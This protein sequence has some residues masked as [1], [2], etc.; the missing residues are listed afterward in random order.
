MPH[1]VQAD[2]RV[3]GVVFGCRRAS[4]GRFLMVRRSAQVILPGKVCFPGGGVCVGESQAAACVR[5]AREELGVSL[6]PIGAVWLHAF[7]DR[8]LTLFGWLAALDDDGP[9]I[10]PDPLEVAEVLWLSRA[11]AVGH[12]DGLPTNAHFIDALEAAAARGVGAV[13][14]GVGEKRE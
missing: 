11:E 5:E 6:T 12:P 13:R 1:E 7:D 14:S 9:P 3:H 4:D 10:R 8:P 2:G